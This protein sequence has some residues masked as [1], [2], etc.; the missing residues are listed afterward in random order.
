VPEELKGHDVIVADCRKRRTTPECI[1][2]DRAVHHFAMA[3]LSNSKRRGR[4]DIVHAT[5]LAIVESP[6]YR[7]GHVRVFVHTYGDIILE[8]LEMV[9]LPVN[10][11]NFL[12]LMVQLLRAGRIP[13]HGRPLIKTYRKS[14]IDLLKAL[15]GTSI[16]MTS[17]GR[18]IEPERFLGDICSKDLNIL[19]GGY[20]RGPPPATL[21]STCTFSVSIFGEVLSS[22]TV[23]SRMLYDIERYFLKI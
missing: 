19:I 4:P 14:L 7:L 10:Y 9:R 11:N 18:I 1:I 23:A 16:L 3:E 5:L 21:L 13:I 20:P 17:R 12:Q 22:S 15:G 2:L 6:A 8:F